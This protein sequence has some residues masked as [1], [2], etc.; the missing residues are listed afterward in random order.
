MNKLIRCPK[1]GESYYRQMYA[2]TT[3]LYWEPVFRNGV[4]QNS[5]PNTTTIHCQCCVCHTEFSYQDKED[6]NDKYF[7]PL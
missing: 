4:L 7:M 1:C 5:N 6:P 3:A 2:T